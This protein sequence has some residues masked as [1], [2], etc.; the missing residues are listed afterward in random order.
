MIYETSKTRFLPLLISPMQQGTAAFAFVRPAS[1][2]SVVYTLALPS[3]VCDT[4]AYTYSHV[5]WHIDQAGGFWS[6][7]RSL[8]MESE[9]DSAVAAYLLRQPIS[10]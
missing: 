2:V 10:N 9:T 5:L 6:E 4:D 3:E 1:A 7:V 8:Q